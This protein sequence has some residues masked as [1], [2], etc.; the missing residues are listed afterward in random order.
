M[1]TEV[2][3]EIQEFRP[4]RLPRRGEWTAWGITLIA[5]AAWLLLV[6]LDKPLMLGFKLLTLLLAL[7]SLAIS[8]GN[9]MDRQTVLRL[10]PDSLSFRNGL[11]NVYL[12]WD[13]IQS[14]EVYPSKLGDKVRVLG[15][16]GHFD[17]RTLGEVRLKG[18]LK[19]QMGFEQGEEILQQILKKSRLKPIQKPGEGYYYSRQ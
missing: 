4:K 1:E 7:I 15:Q 13:E 8:L 5:L 10:S 6:A 17:F 18:E 2:P 14:L 12:R 9:W 16:S 11:R 19:G 3:I